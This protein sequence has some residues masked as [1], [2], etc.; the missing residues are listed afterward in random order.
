[1]DRDQVS[2]LI[3][4]DNPVVRMGLRSLLALEDDII[5][6][7]EA[8]SGPE[9]LTLAREHAPDV[10][11]LD[12]RMPRGGGLDVLPELTTLA[13]V[14]MLTYSDEPAIVRQALQS[15]ATGYLVH[16]AFDSTEIALAIRD[17]ARGQVRLSPPAAAVLVAGAATVTDA[18]DV[19]VADTGPSLS[20][21]VA[22]AHRLSP[23]EREIAAVL[24]RGRTNA[25]IAA[26]L[27]IEE[28][29]VKNHLNRLFA[30]LGVSHRGAAI[31]VL[32]GSDA[33]G[34]R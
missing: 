10:V 34:H 28:K 14:L 33:T 32:L 12:V 15:G 9:A 4:D 6:C 29:T 23:R 21:K 5:V 3:A 19:R 27:F 1:M 25:E 17:T 8:D 20:L 18:A 26:E 22:D 24:V 11:L 2:V 31:A 13:K 7:A 16:G 30:K